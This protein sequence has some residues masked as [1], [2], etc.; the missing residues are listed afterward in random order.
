MLGIAAA[1]SAAG[2]PSQPSSGVVSVV[3]TDPRSGKL[4]RAITIQNPAVLTA[5]VDRIAAE[6]ALPP[7]LVHSVIKV[8]SNYN[9]SAV[10]PKGAQGLM[11]LVPE[12]ARRFGVADV[13]NP[14]DNVKGGAK[15]LK[16]LMDYYHGDQTLA[17]AAYNAGEQNVARYGG[18][19]PFPETQKYV[20]N[21]QKLAR[22]KDAAKPKAADGAAAGHVLE[23]VQPDGSV[24][25]VTHRNSL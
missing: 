7:R 19:P 14:F 11:Q 24:R 3:R 8:E 9:P 16:Y 25:Y 4:V 10:S 17:L 15:Y 6:N 2:P 13:F 5:A 22:P 1:A 12:T 21:V 23:I 20:G 18:V